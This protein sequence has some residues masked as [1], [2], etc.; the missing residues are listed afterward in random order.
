MFTGSDIRFRDV[1]GFSQTLNRDIVSALASRFPR[2][3][4]YHEL[5]ERNGIRTNGVISI[6]RTTGTRPLYNEISSQ[7]NRVKR[8][9]FEEEGLLRT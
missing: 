1:T 7:S 9:R 3:R 6:R 5:S 8:T 4:V 2:A